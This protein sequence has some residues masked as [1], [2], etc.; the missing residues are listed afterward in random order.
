VGNFIAKPNNWTVFCFAFPHRATQS[1][2]L[3]S[4]NLIKGLFQ[5]I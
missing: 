2:K 5:V 1:S 4:V 3:Q